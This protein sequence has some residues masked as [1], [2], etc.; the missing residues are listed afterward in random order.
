MSTD[1]ETSVDDIAALV[2]GVYRHATTVAAAIG[3]AM[4]AHATDTHALRLLDAAVER[5][6]M[7]HLAAALGL[8]TA[9]TTGLVDRLE[10]AGLARRVPDGHDRRRIHVEVT[11]HANELAA[12]VLAPIAARIERAIRETDP[13]DREVIAAFLGRLLD[14]PPRPTPTRE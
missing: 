12:T 5:P 7:G 9:A 1:H 14:D 2:R 3:E 8:S 11:G 13:A 4:G 6:T 10:N